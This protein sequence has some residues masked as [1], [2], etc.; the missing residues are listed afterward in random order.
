MARKDAITVEGRVVETLPH[1]LFR[2]ELANGHRLLAH[3]AGRSRQRAEGIAAGDVVSVEVL[4]FDLSKG[5]I[6]YKD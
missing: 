3:V 1:L 2:V 6:S 4:P 5:C